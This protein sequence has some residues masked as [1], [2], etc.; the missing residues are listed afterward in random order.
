MSQLLEKLQAHA[1]YN[2]QRRLEL[3]LL[4]GLPVICDGHA[5]IPAFDLH[6]VRMCEAHYVTAMMKEASNNFIMHTGIEG[7]LILGR[8]YES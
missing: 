6:E 2:Q 1:S 7:R 3:L 5:S 4:V 8:S